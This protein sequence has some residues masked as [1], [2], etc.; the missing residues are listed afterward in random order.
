MRLAELKELNIHELRGLAK[1]HQLGTTKRDQIFAAL[2]SDFRT[3]VQAVEKVEVV[4]KVITY[5]PPPVAPGPSRDTS[6]DQGEAMI[7]PDVP[8]A[9]CHVNGGYVTPP[10]ADRLKAAVTFGHVELMGPAGSGKTL[11]VHKL[12]AS[13]GRRLAVITADGGLRK[14]DL[15]GQRELIG[16]RT[17]FQASEFAAAARDGHWAL[18]D[19]AN[20]AEADALGFLNGMLD[21]PGTEGSTV[22]VGGK[23]IAVHPDFRCMIT[24]NPGYAGTKTMNEALRDRFW[25]IEV[26][27]LLGESLDKM[28]KAHGVT[29]NERPV[30]VTVVE[31]LFA[32]WQQHSIRYQISPRRVLAAS[33]MARHMAVKNKSD[34][35]RQLVFEGLL[36]DSITTK[37]EGPDADAV[38]LIIS[39]AYRAVELTKKANKKEEPSV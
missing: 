7:W 28:L 12:A 9:T 23:A 8:L 33:Q 10:W 11:A 19:E 35:A 22:N 1:K 27:P 4:E 39:E 38:K 37:V 18:I 32:K 3:P 5:E 36:I 17:V 26:P 29:A 20:M 15:V 24:R 25:S 14:R 16:G 2:A 31:A 13:Q 21:R 34:K 6:L 30:A